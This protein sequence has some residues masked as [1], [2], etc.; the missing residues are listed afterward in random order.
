MAPMLPGSAAGGGA[1]SF[2]REVLSVDAARRRR[3]AS[4]IGYFLGLAGVPVLVETVLTLEGPL[5]LAIAGLVIALA[6]MGPGAAWLARSGRG[7]AAGLW[8][9]AIPTVGAVISVATSS[10]F[11]A[12][13]L[14]CGVGVVIALATL[15]DRASGSVIAGYGW[16]CHSRSPLIAMNSNTLI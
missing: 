16:P 14:Y 8:L 11:G 9:T 13:P 7:T 6:C 15:H 10:Q 1:T 3:T 2:L 12:A 5:R 4:L